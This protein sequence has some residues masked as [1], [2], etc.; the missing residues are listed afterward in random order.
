MHGQ[1][2][3]AFREASG[4]EEWAGWFRHGGST[5]AIVVALEVVCMESGK[6]VHTVPIRSADPEKVLRGMLRNMDRER[7]FVR[8]VES[9]STQVEEP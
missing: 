4:Y 1:Y 6:V 7:Y 3:L 9:I 5:M 2:A 8:E